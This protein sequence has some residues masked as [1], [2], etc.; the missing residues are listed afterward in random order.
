MDGTFL[1]DAL[2]SA[3]VE[4]IH[5]WVLNNNNAPLNRFGQIKNEKYL[6]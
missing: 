3:G 6:Y 2:R 4:E 1:E 5:E